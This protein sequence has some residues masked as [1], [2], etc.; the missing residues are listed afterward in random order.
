MT[1]V[2]ISYSR[3]D[4]AFVERLAKDLEATGLKVWYDLSGLEAG[5]RWGQEI[6]KAIRQSQYF[7]AVLSPNS[8]ESDWVEREFIYASNLNLKAIPLLYKH[9]DL[10]LWCLN[11]HFIDFQELDY[12]IQ[13]Q[14]LLKVLGSKPVEVVQKMEPV[15]AVPTMLAPP[16]IQKPFVP[17]LEKEEQKPFRS[18]TVPPSGQVSTEAGKAPEKKKLPREKQR[19]PGKVVKFRPSWIFVPVGLVAVTAFAIWMMPKMK[20]WLAPLPTQSTTIVHTSAPTS[21]YTFIPTKFSTPT[22]TSSYTF[23]PTKIITP[24]MTQPASPSPTPGIGSKLISS[25]DNMVMVYVPQG[26]FSM[27]SNDGRLDEQ[28]V[29][30]VYLDAFWIDK[31][32]VTNRMYALCVAAGACLQQTNSGNCRDGFDNC[33]VINVDWNMADAYCR[34]AGR[35]LPTEAEW[36]KAARGT[37]GRTYPWGNSFPTCTLASLVSLGYGTSACVNTTTA[38]GS[39]PDGASPYGALDMAG[40]AWEWVND[41][42]SATYYSRSPMNNPTGPASGD[43]RVMRGVSWYNNVDNV[44]SAYRFGSDP[45]DYNPNSPGFRCASSSSP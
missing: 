9:C 22:V 8:A 32:E 15:E 10:P 16:D 24:T 41:W 3:K 29:H 36:E 7:V 30:T 33:P 5:M 1:Q 35:R 31:T 17:A 13:L 38:V 43:Y 19:Q 27:G 45:A 28:P 42:Y 12:T 18:Q 34:W 25:V 4:L 14:E 39:Y 20:T 40:N 37:D 44:R 2:F 6:Q 23:T 21:I 11:L 26:D